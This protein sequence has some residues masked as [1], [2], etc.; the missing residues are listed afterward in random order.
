MHGCQ[1]CYVHSGLVSD[2]FDRTG[3]HDPPDG[4]VALFQ[5]GLWGMGV[6]SHS[7]TPPRTWLTAHI[8][9]SCQHFRDRAWVTHR[10]GVGLFYQFVRTS[11][12]IICSNRYIFCPRFA[13]WLRNISKYRCVQ[14]NRTL[15]NRNPCKPDNSTGTPCLLP[16]IL[17]V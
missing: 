11:L 17:P 16:G 6:M 4:Q 12:S 13:L 9:I 7:G 15:M 2:P 8:N 1:D 5:R 3:P 10:I 14:L